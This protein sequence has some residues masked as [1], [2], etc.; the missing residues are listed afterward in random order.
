[1][2]YHLG[3][4]SLRL[5]LCKKQSRQTRY[6]PQFLE[7]PLWVEKVRYMQKN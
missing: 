6:F 3:I 5:D 2:E 7:D 4:L 1:M